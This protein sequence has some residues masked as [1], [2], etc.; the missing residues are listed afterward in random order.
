[1]RAYLIAAIILFSSFSFAQQPTPAPAPEPPPGPDW[2]GLDEQTKKL[3]DEALKKTHNFFEKDHILKFESDITINKDA[4]IDVHETITFNVTGISIKHGIVRE[5]PITYRDKLKN[6]HNVRF[7]LKDTRLDGQ[8][9]YSRIVPRA[10]GIDIYLG[11]EYSYVGRGVHTYEIE[12]SA[13]RMIGYFDDHDELYWNVTGNGWQF[14]MDAVKATV[15]LPLGAQKSSVKATAYTGSYGN[16]ESDFTSSID[17]GPRTV[18]HF[19]T[20]RAFSEGEGLTI[21]VAWPKALVYEPT[22]QDKLIWF[23]EDNRGALILCAVFALVL[24]LYVFARRRV[25][26][27]NTPGLIIPR[28]EPPTGMVPSEVRYLWNQ[29]YDAGVLACEVVNLAVSRFITIKYEDSY[30]LTTTGRG[31]PKHPIQYAI[32]QGLFSTSPEHVLGDESDP[33]MVEIKTAAK[34]ILETTMQHFA[35]DVLTIGICMGLTFFGCLFSYAI[36]PDFGAVSV[37]LALTLVFVNIAFCFILTAYSKEGRKIMDQLEGL[38]LYLTTAE[39]EQMKLAGTP[40]VRTPELYE[41]FLPYAMAFGVEEQWSAQFAPMF[42]A[43]EK[44][45]RPYRPLWYYGSYRDYNFGSS[46]FSHSISSSLNSTISSSST[47]PGSSSGF[48]GFSSGGGGGG[49]SGG[50]GGGGGGR[51]W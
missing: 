35:T 4:S 37:L 11:S 44:D 25:N 48:G 36:Q 14:K 22:F 1:M 39:L 17:D 7:K 27:A 6:L 8:N 5:F 19:A 46:T 49:F 38:Y 29:K 23:F 26:K 50:G 18:A 12:Y 32:M 24:L 2:H 20:T 45:E 13:D 10:N 41:K 31:T 30:T 43:L 16:T 21:A 15:H 3:L 28:F 9:V 51:G 42:E 40:P 47:P 34:S 33:A